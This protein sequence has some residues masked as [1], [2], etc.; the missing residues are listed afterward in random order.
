MSNQQFTGAHFARLLDRID[1]LEQ[2]VGTLEQRIEDL[3]SSGSS[4]SSG[5]TG[6]GD[7]RDQAVLAKLDVGEQYDPGHFRQLYQS[8]T[9]IVNTKTLKRR[10][11]ALKNSPV[12]RPER[13]GQYL[14]VGEVDVDE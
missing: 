1:T 3:E 8:E 12:M 6:W 14:Y 4:A 5:S 2:Q 13:Y 9:D 10:V 11:R 7:S